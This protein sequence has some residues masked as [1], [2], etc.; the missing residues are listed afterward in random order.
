MNNSDWQRQLEEPRY[1]EDGGFTANVLNALPRQ[2]LSTRLRA[3][4]ISGCAA[5]A[6]VL[7][8]FVFSGGSF[9]TESVSHLVNALPRVSS[10]PSSISSLPWWGFGLVVVVLCSAAIARADV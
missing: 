9:I 4:V 7:S 8:L 1:V 10:V 5:L 6:A 3:A 2:G